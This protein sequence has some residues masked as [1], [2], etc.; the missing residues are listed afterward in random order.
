MLR[1]AENTHLSHENQIIIRRELLVF[2][3]DFHTTQ[4]SALCGQNFKV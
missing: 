4:I 1:R 3:Y 2:Y